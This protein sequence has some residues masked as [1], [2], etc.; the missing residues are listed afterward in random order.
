MLGSTLSKQLRRQQRQQRPND[1]INRVLNDDENDEE[2]RHEESEYD[3]I[4][5]DNCCFCYYGAVLR[6]LPDYSSKSSD[7]EHD[8]LDQQLQT[9]EASFS[10]STVKEQVKLVYAN[11]SSDVCVKPEHILYTFFYT[12]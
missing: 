3:H 4:E 1:S 10:S 5:N 7:Y 9:D 6:Q 12:Y 11:F 2:H 8:Y